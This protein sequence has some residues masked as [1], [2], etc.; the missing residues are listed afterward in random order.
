MISV[1][2]FNCNSVRNNAETVKCLLNSNDIVA[3]QELM[4]LEDDIGFFYH[5]L[6]R[7]YHTQLLLKTVSKMEL[8][9]GVPQKA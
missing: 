9:Q 1:A 4:L 6:I 2:S 3:L 5:H 7:M 8:I